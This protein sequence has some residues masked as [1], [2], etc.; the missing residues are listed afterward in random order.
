MHYDENSSV[1][2]L[3][4]DQGDLSIVYVNGTKYAEPHSINDHTKYFMIPILVRTS[5]W[6]PIYNTIPTGKSE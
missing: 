1:F 2:S 4:I 5:T 6:E 3:Q